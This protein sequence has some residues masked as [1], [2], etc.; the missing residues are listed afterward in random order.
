MSAEE[1]AAQAE[2]EEPA[3]PSG[4]ELDNRAT[5]LIEEIGRHLRQLEEG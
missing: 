4:N 1:T 3:P 5:V 2:R